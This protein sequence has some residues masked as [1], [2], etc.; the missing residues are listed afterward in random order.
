MRRGHRTF[1]LVEL[2]VVL[3]VIGILAAMLL[4]ALS[5]ARIFSV[6]TAG[7]TMGREKSRLDLRTRS[8][9]LSEATQAAVRQES[10]ASACGGPESREQTKKESA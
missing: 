7:G 9:V 6:V 4:P 10:R 8:R 5:Q 1:T 3:A 2:L